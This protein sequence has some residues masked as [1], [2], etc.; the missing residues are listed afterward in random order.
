M[1]ED[2][3]GYLIKISAELEI[4]PDNLVKRAWKHEERTLNLWGQPLCEAEIGS[5]GGATGLDMAKVCDVETQR[6][7]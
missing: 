7:G 4:M 5:H 1:I 6:V 2:P 3:Q